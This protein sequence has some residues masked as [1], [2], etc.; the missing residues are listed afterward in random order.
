MVEQKVRLGITC[1]STSLPY[2]HLASYLN[3]LMLFK[4]TI[5]SRMSFTH[6]LHTLVMQMSHPA[7]QQI[8]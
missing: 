5:A 2:F 6:V 3:R 1:L 8:R 7:S 4:G